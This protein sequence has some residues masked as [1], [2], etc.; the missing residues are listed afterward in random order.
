VLRE[1]AGSARQVAWVDLHT[2]LGPT[3]HGERICA[4]VAGE[5]WGYVRAQAWW[6]SAGRTPVTR[7][8]EGSS[9]SAALDGTLGRCL[10]EDLAH[11]EATK[12]TIEFG[13]VPPAQVLQAMRAEQWL[14]NHPR[15]PA[16]IAAPIKQ[17]MRDAFYVDHDTW[18]SQILTQSLEA[19]TQGVVGLQSL[20]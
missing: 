20:G 12:I 18:K 5:A 7:K 3:G 14:C 19:L 16:S 2:G 8:D 13:T 1:H 4:E 17:A 6:G 15:T 10:S 9:V 11:A